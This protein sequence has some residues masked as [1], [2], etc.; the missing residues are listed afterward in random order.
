MNEHQK[1][2]WTKMSFETEMS[3]LE[4]LARI[5]KTDPEKIEKSPIW[6]ALSKK[7]N[8]TKLP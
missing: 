5:K 1:T 3:F 2:D 7:Y 6:W 8:L 4:S